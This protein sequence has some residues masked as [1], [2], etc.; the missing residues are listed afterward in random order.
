[1]FE[2]FCW[3][4]LIILMFAANLWLL[5]QSKSGSRDIFSSYPSYEFHIKY[6]HD[7]ILHCLLPL[8]CLSC[9]IAFT[10][11]LQKNTDI[12]TFIYLH[13]CW[14]TSNLQCTGNKS[15]ASLA[16]YLKV[17][18]KGGPKH[19]GDH[20]EVVFFLKYWCSCSL[21]LKCPHCACNAGC[22]SGWVSLPC[23]AECIQNTWLRS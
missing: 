1:M 12:Q 8:T 20:N 2:G 5:S 11:K 18:F 3:N 19:I 6:N 7:R 16:L 13:W 4:V 10:H 14:N 17:G 15:A 22:W 9:H 21:D 23:F